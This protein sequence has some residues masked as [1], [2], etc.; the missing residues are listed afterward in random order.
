MALLGM[1]YQCNYVM[2]NFNLIQQVIARRPGSNSTM[3]MEYVITKG[4]GDGVFGIDSFGVIKSAKH[5][6]Y[7]SVQGYKLEA[8]VTD[9]LNDSLIA[10]TVVNVEVISTY[11]SFSFGPSYLKLLLRKYCLCLDHETV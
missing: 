7:E 9:K 10:S 11:Y 8:T 3:F 2:E 4:N 5:I 1:I 6:D